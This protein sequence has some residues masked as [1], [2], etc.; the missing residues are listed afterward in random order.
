MTE[1]AEDKGAQ[2]PAERQGGRAALRAGGS[3]AGRAPGL[4]GAG[5]LADS[6]VAGP[7]GRG[8]GEQDP[9]SLS[10]LGRWGQGT[11]RAGALLTVFMCKAE[12]GRLQ[13]DGEKGWNT[14]PGGLSAAGAGS[15]SWE[16]ASSRHRCVGGGGHGESEKLGSPGVSWGFPEPHQAPPSEP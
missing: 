6:H 16:G 12:N 9:R 15:S 3:E 2:G 13:E 1:G 14:H 5:G 7:L 10:S 8:G 4:A 11:S